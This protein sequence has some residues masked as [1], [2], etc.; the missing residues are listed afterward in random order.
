MTP[1]LEDIFHFAQTVFPVEEEELDLLQSLC[2]AAQSELAQQLRP[3]V[4]VQDCQGAF[5]IAA[6]WTALAGLC[7]SRSQHSN[8]ASWSAGDVSVKERQSPSQQADFYRAQAR[9]LMAP[10]LQDPDFAFLRVRG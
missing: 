10:Y 3:G 4:R 1:T 5:L 7:V 2:E 9:R 6:A 8:V